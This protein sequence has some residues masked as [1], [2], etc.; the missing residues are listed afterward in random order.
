M[1]TYLYLCES[2]NKEFEEFHSISFELKEC[3]LCKADGKL[4]KLINTSSKGIIELTGQEYVDK[5]KVDAQNLK[6]EIYSNEKAY[7]SMLGE[8][9][10]NNLQTKMDNKKKNLKR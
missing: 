7:A 4:K 2:C 1:P 9:L 6:K 8:T 10:Y 5:V 3:P